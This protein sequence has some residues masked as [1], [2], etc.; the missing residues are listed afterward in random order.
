MAKDCL[1]LRVC[2]RLDRLLAWRA[3]C[4]N[5]MYPST[6]IRPGR[7]VP[8]PAVFP[9]ISGSRARARPV[10]SLRST[11]LA[12]RDRA[13]RARRRPRAGLIP[14][15]I[16]TV[17]MKSFVLYLSS[18][19]TTV[20]G[21]SRAGRTRANLVARRRV[22]KRTAPSAS[23][24]TERAKPSTVNLVSNAKG[25]PR[26]SSDATHLSACSLLRVKI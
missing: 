21:V 25:E 11:R 23:G 17:S 22:R 18:R 3:G 10:A 20:K 8:A 15:T 24:H 26:S 19:L 4:P 16:T 5:S 13:N 7:V 9:V 1:L 12:A 2:K 6:P 14:G